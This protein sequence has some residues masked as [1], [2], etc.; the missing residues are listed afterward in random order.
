MRNETMTAG[1]PD[2]LGLA[3]VG[4][5]ESWT[6]TEMRYVPVFPPVRQQE[7]AE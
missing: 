2:H 7:A 6:E 1:T 4:K 3:R 5:G